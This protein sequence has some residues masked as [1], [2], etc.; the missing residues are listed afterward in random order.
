MS[1][2]TGKIAGIVTDE[3]TGDPLIG[4]N[5]RIV[6]S[7]L[8]TATDT[9]GSYYII[10][11]EPGSYDLQVQYIG[12]ESKIIKNINIS[13][14]RT[15]SCNITMMQSSVEGAVVEVSVSALNL[16]KDQTST[17]KNVSSDQIDILPVENVDAII[18]MQAGVVAGSFRGGRKTEVTYLVD[19]IKVDEG[20]SGQGQAVSLEPDA[21]SEIEVITGTFNAEYGKAMSGVVNQV[22]K[23]GSN[24]FEGAVNFSYANYLSGHSNIFPGISELNLNNNQDYKFQV[25]GPIIKDKIFFFLNYRSTSNNNHLNG[26]DYFTPTDTSEYLSDNPDDWI[27]DYSGDSSLVAMNS[28]KNSSLMGKIKFLIS[29]KLKTSIL[30][31][32]N[33]DLWNSYSHA[34]RYNPHGLAH[35]TRS[36]I[37]YAIQSNYMISNSKFIDLKYS[38]LKYSNGYY[39]YEDPMDPR[40]V[41]DIY[42]QS[43]PGFYTG[44][45]EKSHSN[46]E[47]TDHNLKID[48]NNQINKYHNIKMGIDFLY[49]QIK[50]NYYTIQPHPDST[51]YHPFIFSD[52]TLTTFNDIFDVSPKELSFYIQDK[53]EF[54]AMVI[55]LGL[56]YDSFDPNTLYP[57]EYRNPLN[58]INEVDSSRYVKAEV[59]HQLSPRLGIAYQVAD[60]AVMHFSY[61]HFFQ[62]PPFY[63]MY[64]RSDWLVPTGDYETVMG[65]PN[66]SAEKTVKYEIGIWQRINRNFSVDINL[67]YKDIYDLLG[68]KTI[69]TFNDVKYGLYTNKDYGNVR[70]LELKL[71]YINQ[72]LSVLTNYTLQFTRGIADHPTQ[73]F[74]REG[75]SQDPVN[76]LIPMSWDQRH[77]FNVSVGYNTKKYGGTITSYYNSGTTY[78]FEPIGES[79]LSSLNLL[80]NNSYKPSTISVDVKAFYNF[81]IR[82]KIKA[83]LGLSI[84]NLFDRLNEMSVYPDTGRAYYSIVTDIERATYRSTFSTLEDLYGNPGMF[85]APR[86]IKLTLG[87]VFQ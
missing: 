16:K 76:T 79:N 4:A 22:T 20:F 72:N 19:G 51:D 14:N 37:F 44:G 27:S 84:Y 75:S 24:N 73:A 60:E 78:T 64:N 25:G 31:T 68:T 33:T 67:Y 39:V 42:L 13:V 81:T 9:D 2:T 45:Q 26:F 49:H 40:Y 74:N 62:M 66:L 71:D 6:D 85:S 34:F 61:G 38:N 18:A 63:A 86:Q 8:G 7:N 46:R 17:V 35:S 32:N 77:T 15:A 21:V 1:Q 47:T 83:K 87:I 58:M 70:G 82:K 56:R 55:N 30:F 10:N 65:N 52:T 80:P 28:S 69:T 11:I 50:N 41:D 43:I 48:F 54:D 57:T 23:S 12:Y 5:V 3:E 36:T 59:Q 29:G 53:M